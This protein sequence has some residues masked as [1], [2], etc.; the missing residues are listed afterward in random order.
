MHVRL[1][2]IQDN[3]ANHQHAHLTQA[4][5]NDITWGKK[6]KFQAASPGSGMLYGA[7]IF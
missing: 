6:S 2:G 1:R 4:L 5:L 3:N 7:S